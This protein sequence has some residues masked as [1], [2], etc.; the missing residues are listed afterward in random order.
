ME[1]KESQTGKS[2][3]K[4]KGTGRPKKNKEEYDKERYEVIKNIDRE[5]L[6]WLIT[7]LFK[8]EILKKNRVGN[9]DELIEKIKE[10]FGTNITNK[11]IMKILG[12]TKST[13]YYKLKKQ[14]IVRIKN[15]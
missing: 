15:L 14:Q 1:L 10:K 8:E 12:L 5:V 7:D 9:L 11:E 6:E 13:F 2:P 4:G 3:K